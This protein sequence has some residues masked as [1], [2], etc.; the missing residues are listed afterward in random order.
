[1]LRNKF[2]SHEGTKAQ[3]GSCFATQGLPQIAQ[4]AQITQIFSATDKYGEIGNEK[5]A[6]HFT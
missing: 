2:F 1:L 4:I 5:N 6:T 3:S